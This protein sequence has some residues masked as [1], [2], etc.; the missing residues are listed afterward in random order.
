MQIEIDKHLC[1]KVQTLTTLHLKEPEYAYFVEFLAEVG[2]ATV[3]AALNKYP[4]ITFGDLVM[5]R[6]RDFH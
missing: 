5:L 6:Y 4:D 3:K 2:F 1:D